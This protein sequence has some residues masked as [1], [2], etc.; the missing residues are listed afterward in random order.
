LRIFIIR[1]A[2]LDDKPLFIPVYEK[3]NM[4]YVLKTRDAR[5]IELKSVWSERDDT[6]TIQPEQKNDCYTKLKTISAHSYLETL[7]P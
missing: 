3:H 6:I 4:S 7:I 2:R 1:I 5:G